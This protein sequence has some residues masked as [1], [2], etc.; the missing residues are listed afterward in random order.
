MWE[1]IRS[2]FNPKEASWVKKAFEAISF[3]YFCCFHKL[4]NNSWEKL[5][6]FQSIFL[7]LSLGSSS[8]TDM[9]CIIAVL[10]CAENNF[11]KNCWTASLSLSP[12]APLFSRFRGLSTLCVIKLQT[13]GSTFLLIAILPVKKA[14]SNRPTD[15][16]NQIEGETK[17][18]SIESWF[19][20]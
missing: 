10:F 9:Q 4:W 7:Q 15:S 11:R 14:Y 17:F 19:K 2:K 16:K 3:V 12:R 18:Y 6:I 1:M 13:S 20:F 5:Q 8:K